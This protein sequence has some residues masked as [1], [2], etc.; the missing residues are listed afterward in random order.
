M[1]VRRVFAL[2][3]LCLSAAL[4]GAAPRPTPAPKATS[5]PTPAPTASPVPQHP[6]PLVVV[7]PFETSSDIKPDVGN[8]AAQLFAQ[9]MN[10]AGG[11]DA[12]QGPPT[13]KRANYL[14]YARSVNG[15]YYVSG[16]MTP[17][18]E[19][20]SLVEQVVSTQS[21]TIVY[22]V[23][24]QIASFQD[25]AT[26]AISVR[27]AITQR[28]QSIADQYQN[29]QT[30]AT[31]TPA[32]SKNQANL[33]AQSFSDIA[34]LF[35]RRGG[36]DATP[37]PTAVAKP[38]KGVILVRVNG[39]LPAGNLT[40]ATSQLYSSLNQFYN[41]RMSNAP[42]YNLAREADGICGTQRDNTIA[43]GTLS[44][45]TTHHGLGSRTQWTFVLDVYTCWGA[46]LSE[47]TGNA[48]SLT[49]A[50]TTAVQAYADAHPQNA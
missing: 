40:Q 37:P 33:T 39:R 49:N 28:E 16:Y 7:F 22:G 3:L 15:D 44:A 48:D 14:Q 35:K 11:V 2:V 12:L 42:G 17:L 1:S 20:V 36:K 13:I 46:K 4:A 45:T 50:V 26:Q 19:G 18:G 38:A 9:E 41:V 32:P 5:T 31:A 43:T 8:R 23:T 6:T 21:G 27:D 34:G 29:A 10:S 24:A 47:H 25:A 30:S